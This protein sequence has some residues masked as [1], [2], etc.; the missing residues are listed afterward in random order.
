MRLQFISQIRRIE[1]ENK[2]PFTKP[3]ILRPSIILLLLPWCCYNQLVL[4]SLS[5]STRLIHSTYSLWHRNSWYCWGG[6][7]ISTGKVVL[8]PSISR[9]GEHPVL[10]LTVARYAHNKHGKCLSQS[11]YLSLQNFDNM[12]MRV[13]LNLSTNTSDWGLYG[14][15]LVCCISS[16]SQSSWISSDMNSGA[17]S[18][19]RNRGKENFSHQDICDCLSFV[20]HQGIGLNPFGEIVAYD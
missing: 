13:R 9:F 20:I 12:S 10:S 14:Q 6:C 15:V 17:W 18:E 3:V 8:R 7:I 16:S 4:S 2:I 5:C 19:C 1:S 11:S